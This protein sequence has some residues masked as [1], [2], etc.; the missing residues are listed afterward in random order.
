MYT[1]HN[2]KTVEFF[3]DSREQKEDHALLQ[4]PRVPTHLLH[5]SFRVNVSFDWVIQCPHL[6]FRTWYSFSHSMQTI[7]EAPHWPTDPLIHWPIDP[8]FYSV[9]DSLKFSFQDTFQLGFSLEIVFIKFSFHAS[10]CFP[11]FTQVFM[12]LRSLCHQSIPS[13]RSLEVCVIV[14][15]HC[16]V[17]CLSCFCWGTLLWE[18]SCL[19]ESFHLV[20]CVARA[21]AMNQVI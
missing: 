14:L 12:F 6:V 2:V 17:W 9:S 4:C 5:G 20:V 10:T 16:L 3:P 8:R 7:A 21:L 15:S 19:E 1:W 13:L 11:S 18:H